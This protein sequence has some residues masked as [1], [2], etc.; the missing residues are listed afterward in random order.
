MVQQQVF[1]QAVSFSDKLF[2]QAE[3]LACARG[4]RDV[5]SSLNFRVN[6]GDA[7]AVYGT[8][9]SG[10][11]SLLRMIA[12]F[13]APRAGSLS[14]SGEPD[15]QAEPASYCHYLGH[16][17]GLKANLTVSETVDFS[18]RN[19]GQLDTMIDLSVLGLAGH[20]DQ[21]VGDLSAG[22]KR[23]LMLARLLIA[24]RPIWLLDEP[25]TALDTQGRD[26]IETLAGYH[27]QFGGLILA[28]S[29]EALN[30]ATHQLTLKRNHHAMVAL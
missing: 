30:F 12:G 22:Q 28:A 18:A 25:L 20:G 8:N 16:A 7:L 3:D 9:G 1:F 17:D 11:T 4:A 24:P 23:R 26:L 29:H 27:L 15:E 21:M 5:F 14:F 13:L 6:A 19:F 2:L 10:K